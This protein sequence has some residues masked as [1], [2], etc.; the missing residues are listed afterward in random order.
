VAFWLYV[1]M[2]VVSCYCIVC[3]EYKGGQGGRQGW[4]EEVRQSGILLGFQLLC[5][6]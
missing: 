5:V 6:C 3:K 4:S 2:V 1:F